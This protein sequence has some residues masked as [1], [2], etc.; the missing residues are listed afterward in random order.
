M[1]QQEIP[2][3]EEEVQTLQSLQQNK[4]TLTYEI[5]S[6][7][8]Q[9]TILENREVDLRTSLENHLDNEKSF[10]TQL[11]QKYKNGVVDLDRMVFRPSPNNK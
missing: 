6:V 2:L 11:E 8:I 10:Y 5:G 4:N 3:T 7:E 1:E 9:K